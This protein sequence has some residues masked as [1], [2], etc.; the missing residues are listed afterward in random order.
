M[1]Q[2]IDI[3]VW[4]N[5]SSINYDQLVKGID[6]A[7]LRAGFTSQADGVTKNKDKIGRA[8]V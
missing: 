6:F 7:I 5:P 8:H 4:Q 3:S 1:Q 2:G